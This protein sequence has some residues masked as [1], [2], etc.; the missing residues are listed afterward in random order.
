MSSLFF[1]NGKFTI[2]KP[3]FKSKSKPLAQQSPKLN[4]NHP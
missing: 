3:W 1:E 4:K 2:V